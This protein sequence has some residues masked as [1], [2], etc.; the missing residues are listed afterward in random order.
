MI[1]TYVTMS[2]FKIKSLFVLRVFILIFIIF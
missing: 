2:K 1:L